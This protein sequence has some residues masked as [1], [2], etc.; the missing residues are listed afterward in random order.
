VGPDPTLSVPTDLVAVAGGTVV[1]PVN[2]DTAHPAGSTGAVDAILALSYDP[3]EFTVT[4][5]DVQL[6]TLPEG[7]GGWQLRT[8]VNAQTGLI[9]VELYGTA[10][11]N[12]GPGSLVTIT[13]HV[14]ED[15]AAGTTGLTLVPYAD[16]SGGM[17][18][19]QTQVSDAQSAFVLHPAVTS[20]GVEPGQ[21]GM[22]TIGSSSSDNTTV[23]VSPQ[24]VS[25]VAMAGSVSEAQ[26]TSM[27]ASSS[28]LPLAVMEQVFGGMEATAQLMQESV[29]IQPG[30]ILTSE[31]SQRST[32]GVRDL[33]LL[34]SP[35]VT[36]Q[37]DWMSEDSLAYLGQTAGRELTARSADLLAGGEEGDDLAGVEAYF[38]KEAGKIR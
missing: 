30:A 13:M 26:L 32:S 37:P 23:L 4:A 20:M 24:V 7:S 34:Q 10:I 35:L 21:P 38:A 28:V 16:P 31:S 9:G 14:R 18:V 27:S 25:S 11:Q 36:G 22:V 19:Y 2:I 12:G 6:G 8:E 17:R 3:K 33:A 1:V 29:A 5:S 15:A